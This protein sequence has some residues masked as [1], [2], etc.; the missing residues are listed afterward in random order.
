MPS[1]AHLRLVPGRSEMAPSPDQAAAVRPAAASAPADDE[2][3]ARARAGDGLAFAEI[4]KRHQAGV[5]GLALRMLNQREQAEELAQDVFLQLHRSLGAIE[6]ADHLRFWLRRVVLHRA[7]DRVRQRA[8]EPLSPM[9][10]APEP[11]SVDVRQDPILVRRLAA[12]VATL[13]PTARSVVLLR[14]QDDLD[15]TDIAR[16]LDMPLNTVKSHLKRSL[17]ALRRQWI[18]GHE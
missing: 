11:A 14:Y 18:G 6:S 16:V 9:D 17:A 7:I 5:F 1:A 2:R 8:R 3:L 15:P 4:V 12:A 13:A 10:E